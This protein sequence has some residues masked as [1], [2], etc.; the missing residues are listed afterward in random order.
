MVP[1]S[2]HHGLKAV[3]GLRRGR[4][5]V[6]ESEP[7]RPVPDA[8]VHAI[9]PHVSQQVWSSFSFPKL[10]LSRR[11]RART[12]N[13]RQRVPGFF[14]I[15]EEQR[16]NVVKVIQTERELE[17]KQRLLAKRRPARKPVIEQAV[18]DRV[19]HESGAPGRAVADAYP[20]HQHASVVTMQHVDEST[21]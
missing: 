18:V 21:Q 6:R 5:D 19:D 11:G 10:C 17:S 8:F 14:G 7:V 3:P 9:R 2:L 4:A 15:A 1:P 16:D 12:M 13:A 20:A